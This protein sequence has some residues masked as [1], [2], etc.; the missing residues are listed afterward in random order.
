MSIKLKDLIKENNLGV[1]KTSSILD[2]KL[3]KKLYNSIHF[4]SAREKLQEGRAIYRGVNTSEPHLLISPK[5]SRRVSKNTSNL[6]TGLVDGLPSW[7]D[8]PKRSQGIICSSSKDTAGQYGH[9]FLVFPKNGSKIGIC[10]NGDFWESFPVVEDRMEIELMNIF[11]GVFS[12]IFFKMDIS[13]KLRSMAYD[14]N[15]ETY[16]DFMEE[17]NLISS[18]TENFMGGIYDVNKTIAFDIERNLNGD[19]EEYFDKLMNP[20]QNGFKL[21]TIEEYDLTGENDQE[22]WTDGIS[23]MEMEIDG[24]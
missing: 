3:F 4:S 24:G 1:K 6:Y 8:W 13:G 9:E 22:V 7:K 18:N 23:L 12:E 16:K 14:L 15:H 20:K 17:L 2:P 19:W 21:K 5:K 11:N 10:L